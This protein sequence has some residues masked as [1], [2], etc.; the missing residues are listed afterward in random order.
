MADLPKQEKNQEKDDTVLPI[1]EQEIEMERRTIFRVGG[2]LTSGVI[3]DE[4]KRIIIRKDSVFTNST[5]DRLDIDLNND[6]G[7]GGALIYRVVTF[8]SGD[9]TPTVANADIFNTA[10][11]T[12][13]TDFDDGILGQ[14]IFIRATANITITDGSPIILSGSA[15][16]TMTDTDTLTLCMFVDQV[17]S[18]ISRSVN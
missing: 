7:S 17:W 13:I 11:T 10:G 15:D 12:A 9:A 2:G 4:P 5:D 1:G 8:T 18:E 3:G 14:V 6:L 16:Y